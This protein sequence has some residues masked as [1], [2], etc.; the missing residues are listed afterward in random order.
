MKE[1]DCNKDPRVLQLIAESERLLQ[2]RLDNLEYSEAAESREDV[3]ERHREEHRMRVAKIQR[4]FI[5]MET[6][7]PF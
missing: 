5:E 1:Y 2:E 7:N 3:E 4:Q 6:G